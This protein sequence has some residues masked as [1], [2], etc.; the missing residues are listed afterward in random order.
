MS[1]EFAVKLAEAKKSMFG[2][3]APLS[4]K[5]VLSVTGEVKVESADRKIDI[6][7]E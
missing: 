1:D 6:R 4:G 7:K 3:Q 2:A 5:T